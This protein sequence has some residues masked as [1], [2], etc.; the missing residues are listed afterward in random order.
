MKRNK[1]EVRC[2]SRKCSQNMLVPVFCPLLA[3]ILACDVAEVA[4]DGHAPVLSVGRH[5]LGVVTLRG[6]R[7]LDVTSC[8]WTWRWEYSDPFYKRILCI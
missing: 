7:V 4:A 2:Q 8:L 3:G 1:F 5:D 6:K